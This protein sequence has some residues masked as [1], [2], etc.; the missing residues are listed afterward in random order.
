MQSKQSRSTM[1]SAGT[2]TS[3]SN[4]IADVPAQSPRTHPRTRCL[5]GFGINS[6]AKSLITIG[7][8]TMCR[9]DNTVTTLF[10]EEPH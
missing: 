3:W 2:G 10:A 8:N 6:I 9:Y 1:P 7:W 5:T 4:M